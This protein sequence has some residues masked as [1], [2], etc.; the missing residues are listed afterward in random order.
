MT[1]KILIL[2]R[3]DD[4]PMYD[5]KQS[6]QAAL[7]HIDSDAVYTVDEYESLLF[8]YD[9]ATLRVVLSDGQTDLASFDTIF[10]MAWFKTK[11]L[12]DIA[13]SAATYAVAKGVT[14]FNSEVL[15]TRSRT[16]LSQYVVATLNGIK[17]TPFLFCL[18]VSQLE[19]AISSRWSG[20]Y[21]VIMKGIQASRGDDNYLAATLSDARAV[22]AD[23]VTQDG[24][25]LVVQSFIPNDGDYRVVVMGDAVVSVIHRQATDGGHLN[26]TSKGGAAVYSDASVLPSS[27]IEQSILLAKLLRREITGVD[28]I[29][30]RETGEFYLLE[31]NNM[32]QL[33]TGSYVDEK[34]SELDIFLRN[35]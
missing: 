6:I 30:H 4:R 33:A 31:I 19:E 11:V 9:G 28:M 3:R 5:Q 29:Q 25:Y 23:Y 32:P 16:K 12:E 26:N 10:M 2:S 27:V 17:T 20:G 24:P 1:K 8:D 34:M 14:V 13:L 7:G 15:Y 21:P 22:F 35:S 18:D